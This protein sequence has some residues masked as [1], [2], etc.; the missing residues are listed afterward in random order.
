VRR[1]HLAGALGAALLRRFYD[2]GWAAREPAGRA[3]A[4]TARGR[5]AFRDIFDLGEVP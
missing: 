1:A 4:I 5:E 3:L 2:L